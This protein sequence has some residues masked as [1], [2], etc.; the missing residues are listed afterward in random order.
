V[1]LLPE[2]G[3][4]RVSSGYR[5]GNFPVAERVAREAVSLPLYPDLTD[6]QQERIIDA[7]REAWS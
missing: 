5:E 6:A 2:L 4:Y 1:Q 7:V 3:Y